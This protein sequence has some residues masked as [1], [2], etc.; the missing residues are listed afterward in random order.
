[1]IMLHKF[2]KRLLAFGLSAL[3]AAGMAVPNAAAQTTGNEPEVTAAADMQ[4]VICYADGR[5]KTYD[6]V[7]TAKALEDCGAAASVRSREVL[8]AGKTVLRSEP[9]GLRDGVGTQE[10][11]SGGYYAVTF[12]VGESQEGFLTGLDAERACEIETEM[13]KACTEKRDFELTDIGFI[14]TEKTGREGHDLYMCWAGA[15][16]NVLAYTGWCQLAGCRDEDDVFD[17]YAAAFQDDGFMPGTGLKWFFTGLSKQTYGYMLTGKDD[18][19]YGKRYAFDKIFHSGIFQGRLTECM[20]QMLNDLHNGC[21]VALSGTFRDT[22]GGHAI[23]CWGALTDNR[24]SEHET[25]HY[26]SLFTTNSDSYW[27]DYTFSKD[28]RTAPDRMRAL[29]LQIVGNEWRCPQFSGFAPDHYYSLEPFSA[30]APQETDPRATLDPDNS[31]D[32]EVSTERKNLLPDVHTHN[33]TICAGEP[34]TLR[35]VV[36][37]NDCWQHVDGKAP[38]TLTVTAADGTVV[39]SQTEEIALP[40]SN[41]CGDWTELGALPEGT[42]TITTELGA[43]GDL[44][45]AYYYNNLSTDTFT[46]KAPVIDKKALQVRVAGYTNEPG[47]RRGIH[48]LR[49]HMDGLTEADA[50]STACYEVYVA[51]PNA[52]GGWRAYNDLL[53]DECRY[54]Q[55]PQKLPD[56]VEI[57]L[58]GAY[59]DVRIMVAVVQ[60]DGVT[61]LT[62]PFDYH[63]E[64][65]DAYNTGLRTDDLQLHVYPDFSGKLKYRDSG[66]SVNWR[67][68]NLPEQVVK[69]SRFIT[70]SAEYSEFDEKSNTWSPWKKGLPEQVEPT[71]GY[72]ELDTDCKLIRLKAGLGY[73]NDF[74]EVISDP[75]DVSN[76]ETAGV[77]RADVTASKK[78]Y[79]AL[80]TNEKALKNGEQVRFVL[81][82]QGPFAVDVG[83][84]LAARNIQTGSVRKCTLPQYCRLTENGFSE[85][86]TADS[87]FSV[88]IEGDYELMLC[89]YGAELSEEVCVGKL[90]VNPNPLKDT[91]TFGDVNADGVFDIQDATEAQRYLA[92]MHTAL[93][94]NQIK[95][96]PHTDGHISVSSVTI[97]QQ[98]LAAA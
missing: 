47:D 55:T 23:T 65:P 7:V 74:Y 88:L 63:Y 58:V 96:I 84:Y 2:K 15:C 78:R 62:E 53:A 9:H 73:K 81:R 22:G 91:L 25:A 98:H 60:T 43:S 72:L 92:G 35:P 70:G 80:M 69:G 52:D 50:A 17:L 89:L 1:M 30:Q 45:E 49:L 97:L 29:M 44:Q 75:I 12:S 82:N 42:Y 61:V 32:Y 13:V 3:T 83:W 77:V 54:A 86:L 51:Y 14:D 6:G 66:F 56:E 59:T 33:D 76:R 27:S 48:K 4:T 36:F 28:R 40:K 41:Y 68:D 90:R 10:R 39:F 34:I 87:F 20:R 31:T 94:P 79:T 21:G 38:L 64:V 18:G 26:V 37:N 19:A 57:A 85:E 5:Q 16:S 93:T 8:C 24:Y 71:C 67:I 46:V 95:A 11:M